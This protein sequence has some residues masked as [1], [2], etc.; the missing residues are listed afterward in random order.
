M[1]NSCT[2]AKKDEQTAA[3]APVSQY[4]YP[5]LGNT[6]ISELY[7]VTDK[8][9]MIFYEMPISVNQDDAASA[10]N[11]VLYVSP[12]PAVMN[13]SCK[14]L[15]RFT[16]LSDGAIY[17]EADFYMDSVCQYFIFMTN[18]KPVAANAMSESGVEFFTNLFS[19]VKGKQK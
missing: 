9:D 2:E 14:P 17:K 13:K 7:A 8:V 5:S 12:A 10:K 6:E 16:W 15:G 4:A 18:N 11:S 3:P 19:Q 1:L